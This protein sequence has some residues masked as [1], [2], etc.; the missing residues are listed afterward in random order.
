MWGIPVAAA[1][2]VCST[3]CIPAAVAVECSTDCIPVAAAVVCH[4]D[5]F[6]ENV[7]GALDAHTAAILACVHFQNSLLVS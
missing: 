1:A 4:R 3:D 5:S 7:E 6:S 2:V